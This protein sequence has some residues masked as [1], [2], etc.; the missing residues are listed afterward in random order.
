[1]CRPSIWAT[2]G[3]HL[4]DDDHDKGQIITARVNRWR[5]IWTQNAFVPNDTIFTRQL[6]CDVSAQTIIVERASA[7]H[8]N[9]SSRLTLCAEYVVG[10]SAN[11]T[12]FYIVARNLTDQRRGWRQTIVCIQLHSWRLIQRL[13]TLEVSNGFL[14]GKWEKFIEWRLKCNGICTLVFLSLSSLCEKTHMSWLHFF[15]FFSK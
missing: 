4:F 13:V 8:A 15:F 2:V 1:M 10:V 12:K 5:S 6:T 11:S 14:R 9:V 7:S 3:S